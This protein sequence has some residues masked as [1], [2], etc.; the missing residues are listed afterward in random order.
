MEIFNK[1]SIFE[2]RSEV[3]SIAPDFRQYELTNIPEGAEQLGVMKQQELIEYE[4]KIEGA[5]KFRF[6][7]SRY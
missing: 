4:Y 2:L 6:L 7:I 1:Y 5:D 3:N